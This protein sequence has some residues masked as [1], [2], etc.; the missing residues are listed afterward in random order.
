M[1]EIKK[2]KERIKEKEN[3]DK[4]GKDS[5]ERAKFNGT[6]LEQVLNK[7]KMQLITSKL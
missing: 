6:K 1:E 5:F 7:Y 4:C 2:K 3:K